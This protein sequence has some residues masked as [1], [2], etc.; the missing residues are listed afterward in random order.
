MIKKSIKNSKEKIRIDFSIENSS[1]GN[2]SVQAKLYNDEQVLDFFSEIKESFVKQ[3]LNFEKFFSCDFI[4]QKQQDIEINLKK[5]HINISMGDINAIQYF[6]NNNFDEKSPLYSE[7]ESLFN[8]MNLDVK[9]NSKNDTN[10]N[11][12]K[13]F[14]QFFDNSKPIKKIENKLPGYDDEITYDTDFD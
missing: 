6:V 10:I 3:T 2:Y 12:F 14:N 7:E 4:L 1:N 8:T 9:I 5:T 11:I 13:V